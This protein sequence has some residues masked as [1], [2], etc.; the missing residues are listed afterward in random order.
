M[1]KAGQTAIVTGAGS[2]IGFSIAAALA[3]A[4][5]R[6]LLVGRDPARVAEAARRIGPNAAPLAA[7]I[8]D[9]A[10]RARIVR[11]AGS[12]LGVLVHCAGAYRRGALDA[13]EWRALD[14][15]NLHG[16]LL[17]TSAC[18]NQLRMARGQVVFINSSAAL[19]PAGVGM[20]A[21]AGAKAAL[22]AAADALRTEV[23][24]DGVRV[25]SIFPGRTDTPMQSAI[26]AGEGRTAPPGTLLAPADV[27]AMVL[28]ALSLPD[29]AEVTEIVMRPMRKL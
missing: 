14:G 21:Y 2:G 7:D 29:T 24:G 8:T 15:V 23:N 9:P 25:L 5:L 12:A 26:L 16:P 18:L 22:R 19:Q 20:G 28:A 4:G 1:L 6:V 17:L 27:A 3:G 13:A 10:G 11:A